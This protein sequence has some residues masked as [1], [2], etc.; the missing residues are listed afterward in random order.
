[1]Q[2][3][4]WQSLFE[5]NERLKLLRKNAEFSANAQRNQD[6]AKRLRLRLVEE[7]RKAQEAENN[8]R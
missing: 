1:M 6:E 2:Q 5:R 3:S 7:R 8:A 4:V